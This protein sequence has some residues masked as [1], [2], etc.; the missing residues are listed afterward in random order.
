MFTLKKS[1]RNDKKFMVLTP[2]NKTLHFGANGYSDYTMSPR[3]GHLAPKGASMNKDDNKKNNYIA[4]HQV[5]EDWSDL[6]KAGTWS[7]YILWNEK[8]LLDSIKNME[9]RFNIKISYSST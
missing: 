1:T 6:N 3:A 7:R 8:T 2:L 4:R 5:N 9:K